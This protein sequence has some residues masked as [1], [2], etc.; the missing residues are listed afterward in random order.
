MK[1]KEEKEKARELMIEEAKKNLLL[2]K[3]DEKEK[4]KDPKFEKLETKE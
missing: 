1:E 4:E 2:G 3:E